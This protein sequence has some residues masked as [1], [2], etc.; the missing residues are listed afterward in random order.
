MQVFCIYVCGSVAI[1]LCKW[2]QRSYIIGA[3]FKCCPYPILTRAVYPRSTFD[4][5][6][7]VKQCLHLLEKLRSNWPMALR[8]EKTLKKEATDAFS[9]EP[10]RPPRPTAMEDV[11]LP[12]REE[13]GLILSCDSRADSNHVAWK[14]TQSRAT[15]VRAQFNTA[16][17]RDQ[18]HTAGP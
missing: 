15:D 13:R 7:A 6:T 16:G 1:Y 2:P 14:R 11:R 5:H 8:W 3:F 9:Q 10:G 12:S 4:A 17:S 18:Q